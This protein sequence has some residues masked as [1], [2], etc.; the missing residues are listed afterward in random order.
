M[1]LKHRRRVF[2]FTRWVQLPNVR[3]ILPKFRKNLPQY[4]NNVSEF[5]KPAGTELLLELNVVPWNSVE[6]KKHC[7]FFSSS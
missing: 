7:V 3:E 2:L 6:P 4:R 1:V 5:G